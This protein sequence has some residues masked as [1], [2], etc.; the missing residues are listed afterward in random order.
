[1]NI[2]VLDKNPVKAARWAVDRHVSKM[3]TES[4]QMLA[5]C[6]SKERLAAPDCPR[7]KTGET[8]KH[9][10]FN[11]PCSKWVRES[12]ANFLWLAVHALALDEERIARSENKEPNHSISFVKWAINHIE[13]SN[14]PEGE[15]T[16]FAL[17][18]PDIY[19]TKNPVESYRN[20]YREGKKHLH[21]WGRNKP[22]W[23]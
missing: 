5:N 2:F 6:F 8:R 13:E 11:H 18:M 1:M 21:K 22:N 23:I 9:S 12:R 4:A 17:A 3:P 15:L 7:T 19:K 20:L 10:H 14:V 16:P